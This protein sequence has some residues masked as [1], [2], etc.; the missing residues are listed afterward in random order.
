MKKP[1][2]DVMIA[3]GPRRGG[4]PGAP[5]KPDL[6][7]PGPLDGKP[8]AKPP[9]A[10]PTDDTDT[11][12]GP[13]D[14]SGEDAG[15]ESAED[16]GAKLISDIESSGEKF[17]LDQATSREFAASV[18]SAMADCLRRGSSGGDEGAGDETP[19]AGPP[20]GAPPAGPYGR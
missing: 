17:G 14:E 13:D 9:A 20:A 18:F 2:M 15:Y 5:G 1:G 6:G 4:K 12:D 10:P 16:Q 7:D 3:V 11:G 19:P 8:M